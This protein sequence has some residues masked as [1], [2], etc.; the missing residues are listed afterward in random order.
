TEAK[1]ETVSIDRGDVRSYVVEGGSLESADKAIVRCKVEAVLGTVTSGAQ[2]GGQ[3]GRGGNTPAAGGTTAQAAAPAAAT[4]AA[5][6]T[7]TAASAGK[8]ASAAQAVA[9]G[10]TAA[11]A[12]AQANTAGSSASAGGIIQKPVIKSFTMVITPHTPLR[13]AAAANAAAKA[14]QNL[15]QLTNQQNGGDQ[16]PQKQG[17]TTILK[18]LPEGSPV[19][20]GDVVCWLDSSQFEDELKSQLIRYA[21]AKS[22]VEQAEYAFKAA[23]IARQ[24]YIK[25]VYP[26]DLMLITQ[27]IHT[28]K[29]SLK[30]AQDNLKWENSM[31]RKSLRTDTQVKGAQYSLQRAELALQEAEKM[32]DRLVKFTAPKLIEP[33]SENRGGEVGPGSSKGGLLSRR[34]AQ[35]QAGESHRQLHHGIA[36]QG[37]RRLLC[38]VQRLGERGERNRRR[39][40]GSRGRAGVPRARPVENAGGGQGQRVKGGLPAPGGAGPGQG[41]GVR[42][43]GPEGPCSGSHGHSHTRRRAVL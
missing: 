40:D 21:Q 15:Q 35:E 42:R 19:E 23:Q 24:G 10:Q 12:P 36:P 4:K 22:W 13:P 41:G 11:N 39:G 2:T 1:L 34:T 18:I 20:A 37:L 43:T 29:I 31:L 6:T 7:T 27:Y 3:G 33:G 38:E 5:T 28:C 8:S 14:Q 17:S 30:Q 25:G 9:A 32:H 16:Q 26:Q